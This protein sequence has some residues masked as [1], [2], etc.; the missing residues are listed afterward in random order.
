MT[1]PFEPATFTR[2][3]LDGS[4]ARHPQMHGQGHSAWINREFVVLAVTITA[5]AR[6]DEV[7]VIAGFI[8]SRGLRNRVVDSEF[9]VAVRAPTF[10]GQTVDAPKR[11][12]IAQPG[13]KG[14]VA[15]VPSWTVPPLMLHRRIREDGATGQDDRVIHGS[16]R[17][18]SWPVLRRHSTV[19]IASCPGVRTLWPRSPARR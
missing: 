4:V 7:I 5:L 6:V 15:G 16:G 1:R 8:R 13:L 11:E 9:L 18:G 17:T 14:T 2:Q 3:R 12:L 10:T 19:P